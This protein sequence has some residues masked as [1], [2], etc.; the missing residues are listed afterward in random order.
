MY[1]QLREQFGDIAVLCK[2]IRR[3]LELLRGKDDVL[4]AQRVEHRSRYLLDLTAS[5]ENIDGEELR[6]VDQL[7]AEVAAELNRYLSSN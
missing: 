3:D 2:M 1:Q 5:R 7:T 4:V 6:R